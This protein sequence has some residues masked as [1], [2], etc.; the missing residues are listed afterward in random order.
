MALS[1][2]EKFK[3]KH[4]MKI[5]R[6]VIENVTLKNRTIKRATLRDV[7]FKNAELVSTIFKDSTFINVTFENSTLSFVSIENSK[8]AIIN[9][10]NTSTFM[11]SINKSEIANIRFSGGSVVL[12]IISSSIPYLEIQSCD[13]VTIETEVSYIP[14]FKIQGTN[15]TAISFTDSVIKEPEI[16]VTDNHKESLIFFQNS[17]IIKPRIET[18]GVKIK[19]KGSGIVNDYRIR[20]WPDGLR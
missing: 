12:R 14:N 5:E 13:S 9:S 3:I 1:L 17:L 8:G 10:V 20:N 11:L 7:V 18:K 6:K 16:H 19:T 2:V 4:G 15:I